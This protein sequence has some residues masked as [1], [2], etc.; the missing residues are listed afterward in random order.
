MYSVAT[1][2]EDGLSSYV[3]FWTYRTAGASRALVGV[4]I[5]AISASYFFSSEFMCRESILGSSIGCPN[6]IKRLVC[7]HLLGHIGYPEIP[8]GGTLVI[9]Y[10]TLY[11]SPNSN[12]H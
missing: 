6:H 5:N 8:P 1:A 7:R 11:N 9:V 2:G 4:I 10:F 12:V 3:G